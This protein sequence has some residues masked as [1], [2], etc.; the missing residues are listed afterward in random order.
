MSIPR[1]TAIALI[2]T[3]SPAVA[4]GE[5]NWVTIPTPNPS[6]VINVI[7]DS[8]SNA[9]SLYALLIADD[10]TAVGNPVDY[11]VIR[12]EAGGWTDLG[13]PIIGQLNGPP[14]YFTIH[15][16]DRGRVWLG[17]TSEAD[18]NRPLVTEYDH[19]W[20]TPRAID[21]GNQVKYPFYERGGKVYAIDTAHDG[22]VFAVG[23]AQNYGLTDDNS[24]PLFLVNHG[25][26]WDEVTQYETDWPGSFDPN[27]RLTDVIA[28]SSDNVWAVGWH[29]AE[30]GVYGAGGLIVHWD[31]SS[32]TIAEDPR[33]GG[34]FVGFPLEAMAANGPNDIWAVGG[35]PFN[36]QTSAI[37]HY[38]G[39]SWTRIESPVSLS[40]RSLALGDDGTAWAASVNSGSNLAYF[41][42]GEWSA[43]APP[44]NDTYIQTFSRDPSGAIWMLGQT[45]DAHSVA[46]QLQCTCTGDLVGSANVPDG[47]VD[48][49]DLFYVLSGW[50]SCS[51]G[52]APGQC[53]TDLNADCQTDVQD[54]FMLLSAWGTCA[55]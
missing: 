27:T 20:Q 21:I 7:T 36:P 23:S 30:D 6:K 47:N 38:D 2:S 42:G 11:H 34:H 5:C 4:L 32:L 49:E 29:P 28:F 16:D 13:V 37:A 41:D 48:V 8:E 43:V 18:Y 52:C 53:S 12:R 10:S 17:G 19:G 9:Q 14:S 44:R 50:G 1:T 15:E 54:L 39:T 33:N 35:Y 26:G 24:I 40:L 25:N 55:N 51:G 3:F 45:T 46:L 22:T 31:G